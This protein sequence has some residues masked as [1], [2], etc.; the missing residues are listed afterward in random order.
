MQTG[1]ELIRAKEAFILDMDGVVY[2]G[3][4][5]LPGAV[6]FVNW[7]MAENK[8]FLF[9]TN[10]S[11]RTP[12]EL[13]QKLARLGIHVSEDH[14][15]TSALA[16]AAFLAS[17]K[18]G[19]TAFVIGEP[20]LVHALYQVGYTINDV[21]P[22]YVVVGETRSYNYEQIRRAVRLVLNGARLIGTNP[23]VTGPVEDGIVP[24]TR[25]LVAPIE[26]A[27]GVQAYFI[28]KPN[29]LMMRQALQ[30][31]GARRQ[32]TVIIG[33]RIDTDIRAGVES[34]IETVL[35]LSGVSKEEDLHRFAYRPDHVYSDLRA[36]LA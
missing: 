14:F 19:G 28:G 16:T 31:L 26:L 12:R 30:R 34:G 13:S 18:P 4:K 29:P 22:D 8:K 24:A 25:A 32:T 7:L 15:Y 11:E 21:N 10:S 3:N 17:Q 33:D 36:L 1:S 35:L 27:T 23:D 6:E 5:P 9:L 20:G 2:H